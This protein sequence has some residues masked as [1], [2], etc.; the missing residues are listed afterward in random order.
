ME[1][2]KGLCVSDRCLLRERGCVGVFMVV[3]FWSGGGVVLWL[4]GDVG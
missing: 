1:V 2:G 4:F 3:V